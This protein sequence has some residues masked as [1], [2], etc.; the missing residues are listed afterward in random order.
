MI[1]AVQNLVHKAYKIDYYV[2]KM[3]FSFDTIK[4]YLSITA[5]DFFR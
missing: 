4:R 1:R 5:K 3:H 2:V